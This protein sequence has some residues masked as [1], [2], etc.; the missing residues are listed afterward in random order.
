MKPAGT[1]NIFFFYLALCKHISQM[2]RNTRVINTNFLRI[3]LQSRLLDG[4]LKKRN[5]KL[6]KKSQRWASG[7][8][9]YDQGNF[10]LTPESRLLKFHNGMLHQ[11]KDRANHSLHNSGIFRIQNPFYLRP[12]NF[13]PQQ[14]IAS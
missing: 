5:R 2:D 11:S 7:N 9:A 1:R 10:T 3:S 8:G 12:D 4:I 13:A 6:K 14:A